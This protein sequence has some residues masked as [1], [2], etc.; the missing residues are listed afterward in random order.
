MAEETYP[1][2]YRL[3]DPL[4]IRPSALSLQV[5]DTT[6]YAK[7]KFGIQFCGYYIYVNATG[8]HI[9]EYKDEQLTTEWAGDSKQVVP[10]RTQE[11]VKEELEREAKEWID[12]LQEAILAERSGNEIKKA[13]DRLTW[14]L[15]Y[16]ITKSSTD[17]ATQFEDEDF[18]DITIDNGE[19]IITVVDTVS[20]GTTTIISGNGSNG[21]LGQIASNIQTLD[22]NLSGNVGAIK[23]YI[24]DNLFS[25]SPSK[26]TVISTLDKVATNLKG[27]ND[28]YT[29]SVALRERG[30]L[31]VSGA[32]TEQTQL[33]ET[34]FN[35]I[36]NDQLGAF[37][38]TGKRT[39]FDT[40]GNYTANGNNTMFDAIGQTIDTA[41]TPTIYGQI[42]STNNNV[43]HAG[44]PSDPTDP[45]TGLYVYATKTYDNIGHPKDPTDPSD[46]NTGVYAYVVPTK[47][48]TDTINQN[49]GHL[50]TSAGAGDATGV[51]FFSQTA[52]S[53]TAN[54]GNA[55]RSGT[56]WYDVTHNA[57]SQK[58]D[59]LYTGMW[60]DGGSTNGFINGGPG[61][62]T[63]Y[64]K[65]QP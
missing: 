27:D 6:Y 20:E 8:Y 52:A 40:I 49:L 44:N 4:V 65:T 29:I 28:E 47:S 60:G 24:G 14:Q 45:D 43:G 9:Y 62:G 41:G 21:G 31:S 17:F 23:T 42:K 7:V 30:E 59:D 61:D 57:G 63:Y 10:T 22:T 38:S 26:Q 25:S 1:K 19:D 3:S 2:V 39:L 48:T 16:D 15:H 12:S 5:N 18:S 55:N 35:H 64:V 51:C 32:T 56:L 33:E 13:I 37:G 34:S 58:I 50:E 11:S 46:T 54:I 36:S 53:N